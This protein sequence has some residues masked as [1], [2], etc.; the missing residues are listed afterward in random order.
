MSREDRLFTPSEEPQFRVYVAPESAEKAKEVLNENVFSAEE[1]NELEQS[2][3]FELPAEEGPDD[4]RSASYASDWNPED[5]TA[6]IWSG[7]DADV[8]AM[9]VASLRENQIDCRR[10]AAAA[11]AGDAA[12]TAKSQR[13]FVLP[14]DEARGKDIVREIVDGTPL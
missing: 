11:V 1:W 12:A 5:A 7:A 2:G 3:A 8:A 4:E 9:I 13:I 14:E 6:E 10:D